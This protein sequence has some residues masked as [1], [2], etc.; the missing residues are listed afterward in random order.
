MCNNKNILLTSYL[1]VFANWSVGSSFK[2][3]MPY[4]FTVPDLS[5]TN[6]K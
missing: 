5:A 1:S 4:G 3:H 6:N 2:I